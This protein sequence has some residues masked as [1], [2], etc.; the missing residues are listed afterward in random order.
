MAELHQMQINIVE[1]F[2]T[3]AAILTTVSFLP[4]VYKTWKTGDTTGI[5]LSMYS[6]FVVG[7]ICWLIY[8]IFLLSW[9][10]ICANSITFLLSSSIL[11]MKIRSILK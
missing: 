11:V 10:M 7:I 5:S 9:P 2:G 4:Q 3:M 8:G 6:I 1:S